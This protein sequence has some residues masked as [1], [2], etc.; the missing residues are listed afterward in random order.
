MLYNPKTEQVTIR[1]SYQTL[2]NND[3]TIPDKINQSITLSQSTV[4]TP[5]PVILLMFPVPI[6]N[7]KIMQRFLDNLIYFQKFNQSLNLLLCVVLKM[8]NNIHLWSLK[9]ML[10]IIGAV[11][12]H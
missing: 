8:I 7:P 12:D 9:V 3:Q 4:D 1:R 5:D 2:H 6:P 11:V 10:R